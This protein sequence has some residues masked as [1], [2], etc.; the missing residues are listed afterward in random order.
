MCT[1]RI[2]R[3]PDALGTLVVIDNS[4][5]G[6]DWVEDI[7]LP[8]YFETLMSIEEWICDV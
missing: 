4:K 5:F 3:K 7:G 2:L 1:E 8:R 6:N